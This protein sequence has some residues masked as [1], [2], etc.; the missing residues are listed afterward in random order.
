MAARM[1]TAV[2][3]KRHVG[4]RTAGTVAQS[5]RKIKTDSLVGSIGVAG[6]RCHDRRCRQEAQQIIPRTAV[7]GSDCRERGGCD[8]STET[9]EHGGPKRAVMVTDLGNASGS[10][11]RQSALEA[12]QGFAAQRCWE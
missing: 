7:F 10:L 11:W 6:R 3:A 8:R 1:H 5:W 9:D 4:D 12:V 2:G